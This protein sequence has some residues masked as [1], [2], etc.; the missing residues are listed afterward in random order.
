MKN[1]RENVD[2][3]SIGRKPVWPKP[4]RPKN[5]FGRNPIWPNNSFDRITHLAEKPI[6]PK[7]GRKWQQA[8][9]TWHNCAPFGTLF[10]RGHNGTIGHFFRN[11]FNSHFSSLNFLDFKPFFDFKPFLRDRLINFMKCF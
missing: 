1:Y 11:L 8:C 7:I 9:K 4:I 3:T 2:P 6:W 5:V 10:C